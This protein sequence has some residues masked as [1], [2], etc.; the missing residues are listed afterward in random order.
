MNT[1]DIFSNTEDLVDNHFMLTNLFGWIRFF[2][3]FD[4]YPFTNF[5]SFDQEKGNVLQILSHLTRKKGNLQ[6]KLSHIAIVS[7]IELE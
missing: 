2:G 5:K 1:E 4:T 6:Q 7:V 3:F